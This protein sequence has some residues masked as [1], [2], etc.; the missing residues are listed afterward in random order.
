MRNE[1]YFFV[2]INLNEMSSYFV[3]NIPGMCEDFKLTY[4]KLK[5]TPPVRSVQVIFTTV[6][7]IQLSILISDS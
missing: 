6:F 4:L 3:D 2:P 5:E 1:D 7:K